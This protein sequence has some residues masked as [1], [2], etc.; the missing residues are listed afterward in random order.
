MSKIVIWSPNKTRRFKDICHPG[1]GLR[2]ILTDRNAYV[3]IGIIIPGC[4][5]RE[6]AIGVPVT[7]KESQFGILDSEILG[8]P[9][10]K[11]TIKYLI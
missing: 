1:H 2:N 10:K 6:E 9:S 3:V 8:L 11:Q 5:I 7:S 4:V